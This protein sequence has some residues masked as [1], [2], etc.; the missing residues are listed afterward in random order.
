MLL[1]VVR[2]VNCLAAPRNSCIIVSVQCS[3]PDLDVS[4]T[5]ARR[6]AH[7][8]LVHCWVCDNNT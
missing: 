5:I 7:T 8:G 1:H 3:I 6:A 2:N 4:R